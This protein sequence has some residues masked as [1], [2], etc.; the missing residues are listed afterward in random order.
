MTSVWFGQITSAIFNKSRF[1]FSDIGAG[2][3]I[4]K[5]KFLIEK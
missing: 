1:N 3:K 5:T 4:D 2:F